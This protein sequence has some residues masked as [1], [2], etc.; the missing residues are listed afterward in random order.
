M[1]I[2]MALTAK[3]SG[4]LISMTITEKPHEIGTIE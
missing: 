3:P 4:L 2:R 1:S